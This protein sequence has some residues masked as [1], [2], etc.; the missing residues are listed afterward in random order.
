MTRY[1]VTRTPLWD[2]APAPEVTARTPDRLASPIRVEG[3]R[4]PL[5]GFAL[6]PRVSRLT[7]IRTVADDVERIADGFVAVAD[8]QFV[9][10]CAAGNRAVVVAAGV[11]DRVPAAHS[12]GI[13]DGADVNPIPLTLTRGVL[14]GEVLG[15][16][17]GAFDALLAQDTGRSWADRTATGTW[18]KKDF[19]TAPASLKEGDTVVLETMSLEGVRRAKG[20]CSAAPTEAAIAVTDGQ[21]PLRQ[22]PRVLPP[23]IGRAASSERAPS[24]G[25]TARARPIRA[26]PARRT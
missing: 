7:S 4:V 25:L 11:R 19:L 18:Q 9:W 8:Q 26:V 2:A 14:D 10:W 5:P 24:P 13:T 3:D 6:T 12:G 23:A 1:R 15:I 17:P 20:Q 21:I 22:S 16:A